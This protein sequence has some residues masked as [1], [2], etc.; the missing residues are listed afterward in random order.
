MWI[1]SVIRAVYEDATTKVRLN[2]ESKGFYVEVGVHQAG[3]ISQSATVYYSVRRRY[4]GGIQ[5]PL[6]RLPDSSVF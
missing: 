1:V 6:K 2:A 3:P 4:R 5:L